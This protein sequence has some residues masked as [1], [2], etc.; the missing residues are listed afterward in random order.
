MRI[1]KEYHV[2]NRLPLKPIQISP[3]VLFEKHATATA[4]PVLISPIQFGFRSFFGPMDW[5]LKHYQH[6]Q[7]QWST[8]NQKPC[9]QQQAPHEP[10]PPHLPQQDTSITIQQPHPCNITQA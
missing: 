3:V 6:Q 7:Q 9:Q 1:F 2:G 4:G 10:H 8:N 5:T